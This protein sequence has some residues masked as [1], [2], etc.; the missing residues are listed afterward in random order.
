MET[1]QLII[2]ATLFVATASSGLSKITS[3]APDVGI[4]RDAESASA[5]RL[6][7]IPSAFWPKYV[8][9]TEPILLDGSTIRE[10]LRGVLLRCEGN[11]LIVDFGR[12][13]IHSIDPNKTNFFENV[14]ALM[15]GEQN[16]DFPN[17]TLQIGNKLMH[18]G[19]DNQPKRIHMDAV[20]DSKYFLLLYLGDY[21]NNTAE[22]VY[23]FGLRHERLKELVPSLTAVVMPVERKFYDFGYTVGLPIP[24]IFPHMRQGYMKSLYHVSDEFPM[25]VLTDAEG[26]LF[27]QSTPGFDVSELP[28]EVEAAFASIGIDAKPVFRDKKH[29]SRSASWLSN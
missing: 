16:K 21:D 29:R 10:G 26:A 23:E 25:L 15:K 18:F 20:R 7:A 11:E 12:W 22:A 28:Q 9:P 19:E 24:F 5:E 6:R 14:L 1:L 27:Y 3:H 8:E 4:N 17:L 13:G 2:C